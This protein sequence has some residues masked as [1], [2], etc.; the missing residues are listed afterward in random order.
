MPGRVLIVDDSESIRSI[1]KMTLK[2]KGY[3]VTEACDGQEAYDLLK[4]NS[5]DLVISDIA[6]PIMTG[7]ELLKKIRTELHLETLPVVIC[8]A[9]KD[10]PEE[11]FIKRGANRVIQKPISPLEILQ[12]VENLI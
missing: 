3:E 12:L 1:F 5:Y 7:I 11:E 10:A 2:Y 6:M 4:T 9:E 8:T